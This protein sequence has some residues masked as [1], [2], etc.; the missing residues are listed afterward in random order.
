MVGDPTTLVQVSHLGST[1]D[2]NEK[3]DFSTKLSVS[4]SEFVVQ[5]KDLRCT[6]C[7]G[8]IAGRI[9]RT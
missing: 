9:V 4:L 8:A 5:E 7:A 1:L 2:P 6:A 3:L